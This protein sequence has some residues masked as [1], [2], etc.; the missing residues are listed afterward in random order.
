MIRVDRSYPWKVFAD[1]RDSVPCH[2]ETDVTTSQLAV[3]GMEGNTTTTKT[4]IPVR[5]PRRSPTDSWTAY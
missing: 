2:T 4:N 1:Y 3:R 5:Y